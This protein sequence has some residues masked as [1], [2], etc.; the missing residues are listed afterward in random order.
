MIAK[1]YGDESPDVLHLSQ[2]QVSRPNSDHYIVRAKA[3]STHHYS[4]PV[5]TIFDIV[6]GEVRGMTDNGQPGWTD[7][8][9]T[10]F[11]TP[12]DALAEAR[13]QSFYGGKLVPG[14]IEVKRVV[15]RTFEY[16][17]E[18]TVEEAEAR[19]AERRKGFRDYMANR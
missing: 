18:Y 5:G 17:D 2:T 8:G 19:I 4:H 11:K 14:S 16:R 3:E 1:V 10:P 9:P 6:W 12:Q 15:T 13:P 7:M